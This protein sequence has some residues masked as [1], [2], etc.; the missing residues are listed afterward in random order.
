MLLWMSVAMAQMV[1]LEQIMAD[2]IWMGTPPLWP[3]WGEDSR[4][5]Y[6]SEAMPDT[7]RYQLMELDRR[8]GTIRAVDDAQRSTVAVNGGEWDERGRQKVYTF[9]NGLFVSDVAGQRRALLQGE[10]S[11][12]RPLWSTMAQT[13]AYQRGGV[14]FARDLSSGFE[15]QVAALRSESDPLEAEPEDGFRPEQQLRLFTTLAKQ[16]QRGQERQAHRRSMQL[17]DAGRMTAP[18]YLGDDVEIRWSSLSPDLRSMLVVTRPANA[19]EPTRDSMPVYVT[20]SGMV[21][22]QT[23]RAKVGEVGGVSEQV[24]LLDLVEH[25]IHT[26]SLEGLPGIQ[27][28]PLAWLRETPVS[29]PRAV[30]VMDMQWHPSGDVVAIQLRAQDNKDRWIATVDPQQEAPVLEVVHRLTDPAWISWTFNE[31]GWL[32]DPQGHRLWFLSEE[33]GY[34]HLYVHDAGETRALTDGAYE[35]SDVQESPDGRWLYYRANVGHPGVY[36]VW[37]VSV[38]AGEE[39]AITDLGGRNAFTL[40]PDGDWLL[41]RHEQTTRPGEIMVQRARPGAQPVPLTDSRSEAFQ[42]IDWVEPELVVI[43]STQGAG[44]IHGRLYRPREEA[45]HPR[46]AVLFIH[47]AGYLQNAHAGWS[48]YFREF[49]FHTLLVEHGYVVLDIDYRASAGYGREWRT[50]IYRQMGTPEVADLIDGADWLAANHGVDRSRV[51]LYGGS[52][53]GFLTLMALFT[54][55]DAFAAGAALRPVTDWAEYN[56]GYTSNILNTPALDPEAYL[57]SSPIEHAEGLQAPLL[58]CHGLMDDNVVAQ[59]AIRLSQRLIELQKTDWEMALYPLERHGFVEPTA[60]LDEYRRIFSLFET[61]L[62]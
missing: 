6:F 32:T 37:R 10:T 20:Q 9:A 23:L 13:V 54:Q 1:T 45:E 46:P 5:I 57:Q 60:W 62:K 11:I 14:W 43:P 24:L 44:N 21:E 29:D 41:L 47:G 26:L 61:H 53:G 49:M 56:H 18:F 50:A 2:P 3:Y 4:H 35:V 16:Q 55:P 51:G 34:S 42:S 38:E 8:T 17:D 48:S 30:E 7:D 40:S 59:D 33:T 15:W 58:I 39:Q 22:Y 36:D 31:M 27:D 52:Y 25:Q 28:D 19:V 12:G